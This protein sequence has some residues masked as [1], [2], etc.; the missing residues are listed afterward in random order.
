MDIRII[1]AIFSVL[2]IIIVITDYKT[3]ILK[4]KNNKK[5]N[6]NKVL[7]FF[8]ILLISL[9][10]TYVNDY[11]TYNYFDDELKKDIPK[12][13]IC[14]SHSLVDAIN[15]GVSEELVFRL[16]IFNFI[17]IKYFKIDVNK[18]IIISSLLFGLIHINQYISYGTNLNSS[19][20]TIIQAIPVGMLL[21]YLYV[22]TNL[23][24]A[25]IAHFLIYYIDFIFLRCN[26]DIY[27]KM[28]FID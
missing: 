18:S 20:V 25:I 10:I 17:L 7:L 14:Y 8:I 12:S 5:L 9:T 13:D 1:S 3:D 24:T 11:V 2:F 4:V 22:N 27:K 23:T 21:C 16:L 28:L 15:A 26:K 19:I 6:I